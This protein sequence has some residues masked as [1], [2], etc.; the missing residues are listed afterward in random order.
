ML[1]FLAGY[2]GGLLGIGGGCFIY[3]QLVNVT[4]LIVPFVLS[5]GMIVGPL[6]FELGM[7]P[8]AAAATSAF[9]VVF[10]WCIAFVVIV[11]PI[12]FICCSC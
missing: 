4:N 2:L 12:L 9:A 3:L 5:S 1:A 11:I 8:K 7:H 6:L 10:S